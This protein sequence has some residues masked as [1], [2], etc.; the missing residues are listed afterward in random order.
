MFFREGERR[1]QDEEENER[2]GRDKDAERLSF[3]P[4]ATV[5]CSNPAEGSFFQK[6]LSKQI[7]VT[8]KQ[9]AH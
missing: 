3:L 2:G 8:T 4:G 7:K 5:A 6:L 9:V 1:K